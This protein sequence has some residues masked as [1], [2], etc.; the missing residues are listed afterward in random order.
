MHIIH[1][2]NRKFIS[3]DGE[4]K[5]ELTFQTLKVMSVFKSKIDEQSV[6][7]ETVL[8]NRVTRSTMNHDK[9]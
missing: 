6:R 5:L 3:E 9:D 8:C 4:T 7:G 2:K 1:R